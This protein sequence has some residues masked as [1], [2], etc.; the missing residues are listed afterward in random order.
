MLIQVTKNA[1]VNINHITN[2]QL[3]I[4]QRKCKMSIETGVRIIT[5]TDKKDIV[6]AL[7]LLSDKGL[8]LRQPMD[9]SFM[10]FYDDQIRNIISLDEY[11]K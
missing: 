5:L 8:L 6:E 4:S 7:K 2:I 1:I 10:E 9:L 11:V 3:Y